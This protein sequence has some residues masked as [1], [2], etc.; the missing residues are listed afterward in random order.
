MANRLRQL[1]GDLDRAQAT[2]GLQAEAAAAA[3]ASPLL[4]GRRLEA[5]LDAEDQPEPAASPSAASPI[6][7]LVSSAKSTLTQQNQG[8]PAQGIQQPLIR[9]AAGQAEPEIA[10]AKAG[11]SNGTAPSPDA[12]PVPSASGS[13]LTC[14]E[15]SV[16]VIHLSRRQAVAGTVQVGFSSAPACRSTELPFAD[17]LLPEAANQLQGAV[18]E[19]RFMLASQRDGQALDKAQSSLLF[20]DTHCCSRPHTAAEYINVRNEL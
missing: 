15:I 3:A 14:L 18:H 9:A 4:G 7:P 16:D 17:G 5:C 20:P 12:L 2:L 11:P 10:E 1:R 19:P 13:L 8:L 6:I